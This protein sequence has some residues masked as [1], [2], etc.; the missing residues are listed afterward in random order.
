METS[1]EV[2]QDLTGGEIDPTSYRRSCRVILQRGMN[3]GMVGKSGDNFII[4]LLWALRALSSAPIR[5][6]VYQPPKRD[7]DRP[8]FCQTPSACLAGSP[9]F[10]A[11]VIALNGAP[12]CLTSSCPWEGSFQ[13]LPPGSLPSSPSL[14]YCTPY[15]APGHLRR[16]CVCCPAPQPRPPGADAGGESC[17]TSETVRFVSEDSTH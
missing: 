17:L 8:Q 14:V 5:C 15:H 1:H 3:G 13:F 10:S 16:L 7:H 6:H 11:H 12:L 4:R 2:G 9:F